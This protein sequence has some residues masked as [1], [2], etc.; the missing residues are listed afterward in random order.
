MDSSQRWDLFLL[1]V[2]SFAAFLVLIPIKKENVKISAGP[3]LSFL[4]ALFAEMYG[5]PLSIFI[6]TSL[7]GGEDLILRFGSAFPMAYRV[8]F[9]IM[10]L[11]MSLVFLGWRRIYGGRGLVTT[12]VYGLVRHPQYLG[13]LLLT[14]GLF[15]QWPTIP[16]LL[17]WPILVVLYYRLARREEEKLEEIFGDGYRRYKRRVPMFLPRPIGRRSPADRPDARGR[18]MDRS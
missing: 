3:Y 2:L 1:N 17:M 4:I 10:I 5:F 15:I 9:A 13:I 12:G 6:I 11:G 18:D 16:T 8:G 7:L 14:L